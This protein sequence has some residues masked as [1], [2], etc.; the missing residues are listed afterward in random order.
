MSQLFEI[1]YV[2]KETCACLTRVSVKHIRD[3]TD[4]PAVVRSI[5]LF[6]KVQQKPLH[7][8]QFV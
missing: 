6:H 7:F 1:T 2:V 3:H 8:R 4:I 5:H